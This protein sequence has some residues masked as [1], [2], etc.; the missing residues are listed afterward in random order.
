NIGDI[1]LGNANRFHRRSIR[2]MP[3]AMEKLRR[4]TMFAEVVRV[5]RKHRD[6]D[7]LVRM[8][9]PL[10]LAVLD[11][12]DIERRSRLIG[13]TVHTHHDFILSFEDMP[14]RNHE[15]PI[16][17]LPFGSSRTDV[18]AEEEA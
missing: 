17:R 5:D 15:D 11:K 13:E 8:S 12:V 4:E 18:P 14:I 9:V 1:A 2:Y 3:I 6:V 10:R 7:L 16:Q